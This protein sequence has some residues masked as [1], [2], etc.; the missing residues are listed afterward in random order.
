MANT[1]GSRSWGHIRKLPSGRYQ[2]SYVHDLFRRTAPITFTTKPRAEGWLADERKL[3]E[4]G[5]WTPPAKRAAART[6]T[7]ITLGDYGTKWIADRPLKP[8][9]RLMYESLLAQ[10]ITPT[11]GA[12]PIDTIT[13]DAVRSWYAKLGTEHTRRNSHIYGLA[14]AI[15]ATA[16]KDGLLQANPCQIQRV[17]NPTR[18]REP[19]ILTVAQ[20]A[21]LAAKVP[22]RLKAAVLVSAWCGVRFGELIELR[23]KDIDVDGEVL[24]V[25]RGATHRGECRIDTPKGGKPRAIV[26]PPHIR[27]DLKHHL[28]VYAQQGAEG[29]VF[30]PQRG[31]CHL[32]DKVLRDAIAGPLKDIGASGLRLHDL[33]HFA[34]TQIARCGNLAESMARLGH[35]TVRAALIYQSVVSGR[36]AEIA[37]ALSALAAQ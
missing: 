33:R 23:R 15:M 19:V 27:A 32:N 30:P 25:G 22:E 1:K 12:L 14:H 4:L 2:A 31:G 24:Y 21:D 20:V 13:A 7:A 17:M 10:H 34:G 5:A 9:T 6:A 16:V 28:D 18:K 11:L 8:R 37:A 26:I 36:D 29:L 35:S 3:I